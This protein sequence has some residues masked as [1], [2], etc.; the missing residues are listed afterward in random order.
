MLLFLRE[1]EGAQPEAV[2]ARVEVRVI[3]QRR[4]EPAFA[5]FSASIGI[6]DVPPVDEMLKLADAACYAI[7]RVRQ[8]AA[9]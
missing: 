6:V 4:S 1:A 8:R 5:P 9:R 2:A 3:A 7:K